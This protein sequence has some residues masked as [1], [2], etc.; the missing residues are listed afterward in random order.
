MGILG[1]GYSVIQPFDYGTMVCADSNNIDVICAGAP[2]GH[3]QVLLI[4]SDDT[5]ANG[6]NFEFNQDPAN[7]YYYPLPGP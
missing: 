7:T 5:G 6:H 2:A 3:Y 1:S 4:Q